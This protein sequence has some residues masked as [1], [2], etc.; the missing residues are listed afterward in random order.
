MTFYKKKRPALLAIEPALLLTPDTFME[1]EMP[2]VPTANIPSRIPLGQRIAAARKEPDYKDLLRKER[3]RCKADWERWESRAC[4]VPGEEKAALAGQNWAPGEGCA[5][6]SLEAL[7][8]AFEKQSA[9]WEPDIDP[10]HVWQPGPE[11]VRPKLRDDVT[12][13]TGRDDSANARRLIDWHGGNFHYVPTSKQFVVWQGDHWQVGSLSVQEM[14][15]HVAQQLWQEIEE[16]P[17]ICRDLKDYS[18][19]RN[20]ASSCNNQKSIRATMDFVKS[21]PGAVRSDRAFDA[22]PMLLNLKNGTL[23]LRNGKLR[24]HCREDL[25]TL[26]SPTTFDADAKCPRWLAFLDEIF[27][28]DEKLIRYVK[29]LVGYTITGVVEEHILPFLYGSGSNGKSTFVEVVRNLLGCGYAMKTTTDFLVKT[30]T[31]QNLTE[32]A[33]LRKKRFVYGAET[34]QGKQLDETKIKE[35]T[36]GDRISARGL[37]ENL[38]EFDPSHKVYITGNH[39]PRVIGTDN[40][41]WRRVKLIPFVVTIPPEKQDSNLRNKLHREM[42]GILNWA[43]QGCLDWQ[44]NGLQEPDV[45][46]LET[47]NYR[48]GEDSIG[49]FLRECCDIGKDYKAP[50]T[51][52][53]QRFRKEMESDI[54][55]TEFGTYLKKDFASKRTSSGMLYLGLRLARQKKIA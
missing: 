29:Q 37:Y 50:A 31:P 54:S 34:G 17:E 22:D 8:K 35:L 27:G 49:K 11:M 16:L 39:K 23:D 51:E 14:C 25:L 6:I 15:K 52:L 7:E 40:G 55:Q 42:P 36:G 4:C 38:S 47:Q 18:V 13:L 41:I 28:K 1:A 2:K 21:D 32:V 46:K 53:Y 24:A 12:K 10:C 43:I 19:Y 20:Y 48:E 5:E 44:K 30:I 45:V 26:I 9:L 33:R 3:G